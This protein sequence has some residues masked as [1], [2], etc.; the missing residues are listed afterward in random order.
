MTNVSPEAGVMG[1]SGMYAPR[2][3]PGWVRVDGPLFVEGDAASSALSFLAEQGDPT[4]LAS[5]GG[6]SIPEEFEDSYEGSPLT[7]GVTF[8]T[9]FEALP[10]QQL[11]F[12]SMFIESNDTIVGG[13]VAL[14]DGDV[15][16]SG[17]IT[18]DFAY[19]DVGSEVNEE[20]GF[21]EGQPGGTMGGEDE[22]GVVTR[23]EVMDAAGFRY[24]PLDSVIRFELVV[25]ESPEC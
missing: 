25:C 22:A 17:D 1:E 8:R 16:L 19:F 21:G 6:S 18:S 14:F 20:P 15:P 9:R 13:E 5:S 11:H 4:G 10:G 23:F 24:A 12:A 7:S 2:F 3:S